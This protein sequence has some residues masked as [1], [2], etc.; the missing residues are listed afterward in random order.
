MFFIIKII[1]LLY[2]IIIYLILYFNKLNLSY[3]YNFCYKKNTF[4]FN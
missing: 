2:F 1:L 3:K 4:Y